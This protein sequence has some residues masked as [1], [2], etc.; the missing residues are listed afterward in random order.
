MKN[1]LSEKLREKYRYNEAKYRFMKN[2]IIFWTT[3][4]VFGTIIV[5]NHYL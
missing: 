3:Y 1:P 2:S 4:L 5:I